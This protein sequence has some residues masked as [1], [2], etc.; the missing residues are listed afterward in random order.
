[1]KHP[2]VAATLLLVLLGVAVV[3]TAT[4]G[5]G[6]YIVIVQPPAGGAD[7]LAYHTGILAAALGSEERAK[8]ALL[9]SYR[10]VASGFAAVLTP[11]ELAALQKNPAVIQVRPDQMYHVV[12]NLN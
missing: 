11:P 7:T 8:V 9:Y 2:S 3:S 6:V 10:T 1:M 12:D 4:D 5:A